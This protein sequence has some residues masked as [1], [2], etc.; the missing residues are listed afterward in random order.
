MLRTVSLYGS[1]ADLAHTNTLQFDVDTPLMLFNALRSQVKG[2]RQWCDEHKLAFVVTD[3]DNNQQSLDTSELTMGLGD[4]S[5]IHLVPET[6]GAGFEIAAMAVAAAGATGWAATAIYIA[7]NVAIAVVTSMVISALS[8][9]PD[10]G[11]GSGRP[12]EK[13]S[14]IYNGAVNVVEQ[15]Y[16]VPLVYGTHMVGSIVVSAGITVEDIPYDADQ[17]APPANGGGDP[18]PATPPTESW[19]WEAT[20]GA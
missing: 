17:A 7:V 16:P 5:N 12:D 9:S 6:E 14:F 11:G 20:G 8:P 18:Q 13:P 4:A 10:S 19:Q 2:F 15:G 3:K 1:L